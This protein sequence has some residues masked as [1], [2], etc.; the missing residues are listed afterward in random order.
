MRGVC[1]AQLT[2]DQITKLLKG[3]GKKVSRKK[4]EE[5]VDELVST[6]IYATDLKQFM[7]PGYRFPRLPRVVLSW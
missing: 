3:N 1:D 7:F 5:L 2:V 4:K 6:V